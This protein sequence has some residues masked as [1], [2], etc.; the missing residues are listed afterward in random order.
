MA[1][2][3]SASSD[4][5]SAGVISIEGTNVGLSL[6]NCTMQSTIL[7]GVV[8]TG[9]SGSVAADNCTWSIDPPGADLVLAAPAVT[10][11]VSNP[12]AVRLSPDSQ[13]RVLPIADAGLLALRLSPQDAAFPGP[14]AGVHTCVHMCHAWH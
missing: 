5:L 8:V 10:A 7:A 14:E 12:E 9:T 11:Y 3:S 13:G 2:T 1:P 6:A 4:A